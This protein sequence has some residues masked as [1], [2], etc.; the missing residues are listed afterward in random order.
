MAG[1]WS[2]SVESAGRLPTSPRPPSFTVTLGNAG[3][4]LRFDGDEA[5][6]RRQLG[7]PARPPGRTGEYLRRAPRRGGARDSF[8]HQP[9]MPQARRSVRVADPALGEGEVTLGTKEVRPYPARCNALHFLPCENTEPGHCTISP[10]QYPTCPQPAASSRRH[11]RPWTKGTPASVTCC[12]HRPMRAFHG[13]MKTADAEHHCILERVPR[14]QAGSARVSCF[15][16]PASMRRVAGQ[17]SPASDKPL[18]TPW[19]AV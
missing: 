16:R 11:S 5:G 9:H 15:T 12:G 2:R 8:L 14:R 1:R 3:V 4:A 10:S 6:V 13:V 19:A 18:H 7:P 17:L